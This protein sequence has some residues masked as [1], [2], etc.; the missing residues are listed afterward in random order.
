MELK[1]ELKNLKGVSFQMSYPSKEDIDRIKDEKKI[2]Q[3][4]L[5]DLPRETVANV[6]INCLANYPVNDKKEVFLVQAVAAWI[7]D[8]SEDKGT[9]PEKLINFLVKQVLPEMT[10]RKIDGP[11]GKKEEKGMYTGWVMAQIYNELGIDKVE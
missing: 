3:V 4:E 1:K 9:L 7:N 2:E 5:K 8:E 11:E 10:F 6:L